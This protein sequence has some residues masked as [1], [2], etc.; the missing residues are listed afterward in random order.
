ME[1]YQLK[2]NL[3]FK[4]LIQFSRSNHIRY[5]EMAGYVKLLSGSDLFDLRSTLI[6]LV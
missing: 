6:F 2:F 4:S 3:T 1:T 5:F